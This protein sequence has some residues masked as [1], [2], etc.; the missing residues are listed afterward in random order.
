M[1]TLPPPSSKMSNMLSYIFSSLKSRPD[2]TPGGAEWKKQPVDAG[3][4]GRSAGLKVP[5]QTRNMQAC[6]LFC[7]LAGL[8]Y[9]L[10][11]HN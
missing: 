8:C 1:R 6:G 4:P 2:Q 7:G 3:G 11:I 9:I 5:A 10:F